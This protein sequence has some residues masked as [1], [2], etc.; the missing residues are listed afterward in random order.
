[1]SR[2]VSSSPNLIEH[3]RGERILALVA[4]TLV[5]V[6]T[7]S[8]AVRSRINVDDILTAVTSAIAERLPVTCIAILMKI[9]PDTSR[10]VFA[11]HTNPGMARYLDDYIARL[12]RPGE[13]PTT[14]VASRVIETG[15]PLLIP[16]M[17]L[18]QL[19]GM[20][21]EEVRLPFAEA[22]LPIHIEWLS[23]L[24]VPMR[25]GPAIIGTLALFDWQASGTLAEIDIDWMQTAADRVG[26]TVDSAQLRNRAMERA[27]RIAA[28]S[29]VAMAVT[30]TQD[31][32][33][34]FK[35]ILERV[36][37]ALRVDA[38]D[39]LLV[40]ESESM[41]YV[42]ASAGF[43][44]GTNAEVRGQMPS[45]AG[46]KWVIGHNIAPPAAIEWIGQSR[47]WLIAR[48]GLK[49]Y[50]A[51]PLQLRE[52]FIG[53]LEVF[54]REALDPDREWITF[55]D[56]MASQAAIA[57]DNTTI[58]DTLRRYGQ[59]Q[60]SHRAP[61]PALSDRE[62]EILQLI[63]DGAS[64]REAAEKLHLSQNTIK[65]HV[66]QLL[67]KAQVANRTELASKALHQGWVR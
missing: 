42:A 63:V 2:L 38:A 13:A 61:A 40:D 9:D 17:S 22:P 32:R 3:P 49:S 30:S 65:F 23:M 56:A 43:R 55:L 35:L 25:A 29:D 37:A 31:L 66:R 59:A 12:L 8:L 67:E 7:D 28:L 5:Q 57:Y 34:T 11:D 27:E 50:T 62:R 51:A 36:M 1:L 54:S 16:K 19:R 26:L 6:F 21:S 39:I 18:E 20:T 52:K 44:M 4:D 60:P 64:N 53:A 45:E 14:G 15:G 24:M 58:H 33:V 47:R 41:V 10:V 46:V 48:E